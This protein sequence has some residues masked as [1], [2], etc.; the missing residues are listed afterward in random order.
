M[1]LVSVNGLACTGCKKPSKSRGVVN[2]RLAGIGVRRCW[3]PWDSRKLAPT[4]HFMALWRRRRMRR[5]GSIEV[6]CRL[7]EKSAGVKADTP[8]KEE[9]GP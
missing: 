1:R 9:N 8:V 2:F 6:G 4:E 5:P 7:S 3:E